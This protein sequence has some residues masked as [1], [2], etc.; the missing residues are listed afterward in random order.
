MDSMFHIPLLL[1][2]AAVA[3]GATPGSGPESRDDAPFINTWLVAGCF[4]NAADNAGYDFDWIGETGAAPALGAVSGGR[5]WRYFDDRLFSRNL[6]D[7]QDLFSYFR[8]KRGESVAAQVAYAHVYVYSPGAQ[9]AELRVGADTQFK[10]WL[11]GALA[12]SSAEELPERDMSRAPVNLAPGWNRLLLKVANRVNGRFGF[13]ARLCD[14]DGRALDGIAYSV[15]TPDRPLA[16]ATQAMAD[17]GTGALPAAYREWSYVGA[18]V[19]LRDT[20]PPLDAQYLRKP[21]IALRASDFALTAE[22]G[23]PP[24]RWSLASGALPAGIELTADGRLRGT[25]AGDAP[26]GVYAFAIRVE[27]A[28]GGSAEKALSLDLSERPNRWFEE[29]RLTALIHHPE[30]MP[31]DAFDEFA[32]LMKRQGYGIGM[33]IAYNNGDYKYRWPSL[34]EP[35]NPEGI[36]MGRYKNALEQAGIRF[37][38]Y[39]GN[40]TGPNHGGDNG[41]ILLVE[42]ALRRYRPAAFWFDWAG[43][44]AVSPD[45][46][47]SMIKSYDPDALVVLNGIPTLSNGD[48]D[49]IN[50]EGWGCW[51]E[52]HWDL[53]PFHFDWPKKHAVEA[54]RLLADP[55][56]EYSPGVHAD[57]RAY[58]RLQL[59]LIGDGFIANIDHSPTIASGIGEDGRLPGLNASPLM[60]A[61]RA[62]A[63]WANPAGLPPLHEAYTQV[64]PGPLRAAPWGYNTINLARDAVYLIAVETPMGKTGL[65]GEGVLAVGP[66][67]ASVAAAVC[68]NTGAALDF[69]QD[70]PEVSIDIG[71]IAPDPV[72]TIVK[73]TLA[74]PHPDVDP[75]APAA[76]SPVPPGNLAWRKPGALLSVTGTRVLPASAW[77]FAHYAVDGMRE[78]Y[79]CGADEW[80][81]MYHLDLLDIHEMDRI[82]LHFSGRAPDIPGYPTEYKVHI[83]PDA[84]AW[85]TV[86][87]V[88][89]CEG[90]SH[91]HR[92]EARPARYVRVEAVKPDGPG[93]E[94]VQM[95]IAELEVYA[96]R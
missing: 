41:A 60:A 69:T 43:W 59:A 21:S 63:A 19:D 33:V 78:T 64:N 62:M 25:P 76:D 47:Y 15:N 9:A 75:P 94:G 66:L 52:R 88:A 20:W 24:Y 72:A 80:A 27:D 34:F 51:G 6:D 61:H 90:G 82:V 46:V 53:W 86:A 14:A 89:E 36:L 39:I 17:I 31:L 87:H 91:E 49:V 4:D 83:S 74:A 35:D 3:A 29:A 18:R 44:D 30:S 5:P 71:P 16:V 58:M 23:A 37:G 45:A 81:W 68:M 93:Q 28:A 22:G 73:L 85:T 48:W 92:F 54:W 12:A 95:H 79:A 13:Y 11:N 38:M 8:V 42:D 1:L 96:A 50:L 55:E 26:L 7:Y 70:G 57:W 65:P 32:D 84:S 67:A 40:L 2:S 10:A 77:R 56:F